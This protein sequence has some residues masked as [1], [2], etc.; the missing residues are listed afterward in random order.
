MDTEVTTSKVRG[1]LDVVLPPLLLFFTLVIWG[2]AVAPFGE[3]D[4]DYHL[5]SIYCSGGENGMCEPGSTPTT[6]LVREDA[7][8]TMCFGQEE[9]ENDPCRLR[10]VNSGQLVETDRGNFSEQYPQLFY[11]TAALALDAETSESFYSIRTLNSALVSFGLGLLAAVL[12]LARRR[13]L[14]MTVS[15]T[16]VP[17]G[18][19]IIASINPTSWTVFGPLFI[20]FAVVGVFETAGWRRY[21]LAALALTALLF[22]G[23]ARYDAGAYCLLAL[24]LAVFVTVKF[25]RRGTTIELTILGLLGVTGIFALFA[26]VLD[27]VPGLE[28][29]S[30]MIDTL[31]TG[32]DGNVGRRNIV[33]NTLTVPYIWLGAFGTWPLG[34]F[35]VPIPWSVPALT[36]FVF[37]GLVFSSLRQIYWRTAIASISVLAVLIFVPV[38]ILFDRGM[39]VGEWFQPR[40]VLALLVLFLGILIIH[41]N[42]ELTRSQRITIT[43]S[44]AVAQLI[45]L[46]AVALRYRFGTAYTNELGVTQQW[47]PMMYALAGG[48]TF[49]IF[50]GYVWLFLERSGNSTAVPAAAS[51]VATGPLTG[52]PHNVT[53]NSPARSAIG[54]SK[55]TA[56]THIEPNDSGIKPAHSAAHRDRLGDH[57]TEK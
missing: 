1:V 13:A 36:I 34:W 42:L 38:Y 32:G 14:W 55:Q 44:L 30:A 47:H 9:T 54:Y 27:S 21:V 48:V 57:V 45:A 31:V 7:T 11:T 2:Y 29:L 12:P 28:S 4:S 19:F 5:A 50:V 35:D 40:Y 15:A 51:L 8:Q 37:C 26:G 16:V 52:D 39:A 53:D 6:R 49:A 33:D 43:I 18:L 22:V 24:F 56:N 23:G 10:S 3:P 25:D 41:A 20:Y 46:R 17:L